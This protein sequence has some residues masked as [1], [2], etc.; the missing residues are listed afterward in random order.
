MAGRVVI[1]IHDK[2]G[3]LIAYAGR[4]P[5]DPPEGEAKYKLPPGFKKRLELFNFHRAIK[6]SPEKKFIVVEGFFDCFNLW[7]C[8]YKNVV[9]LMGSALSEEQEALLTSQVEMVTLMLDQ[10]DAGRKAAQEILP[11]LARKFFVRVIELPAE[12]DQPDKL[13]NRILSTLFRNL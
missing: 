11:R 5:G 1:P 10:D 2:S 9:G 13:D 3:G 7:Q 4:W 8:G 12:G 6:E